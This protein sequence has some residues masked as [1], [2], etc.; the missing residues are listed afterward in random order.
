M[1]RKTLVGILELILGICFIFVGALAVTQPG[2][3]MNSLVLFYGIAVIIAG[4]SSIANYVSI[5]KRLGFAPVMQILNGILAIILGVLLILNTHI[6]VWIVDICFPIWLIFN[7]VS[8]LCSLNRVKIFSKAL[9]WLLLI[10][11]IVGVFFGFALLLH[12]VYALMTI[13]YIIAVYLFA[14]GFSS[15]ATAF[16]AF[17][18]KED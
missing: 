12:P 1:K 8:S 17:F 6:G 13:E 7:C 9:F 3:I 14:M 18:S 11:N 2:A 10:L 15:V 5:E 4:I 16:A